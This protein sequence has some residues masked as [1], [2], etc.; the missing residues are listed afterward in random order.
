MEIA[1]HISLPPEY[2]AFIEDQISSG[3]YATAE[4]VIAD[5]LK[6]RMAADFEAKVTKRVEESMAAYERGDYVVADDKYFDG[7]RE[8]IRQKYE[9]A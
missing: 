6:E 8:R 4:D 9:G 7:L 1:M 3:Q 5:A 2:E